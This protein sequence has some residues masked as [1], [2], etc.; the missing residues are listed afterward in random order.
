MQPQIGPLAGSKAL[1]QGYFRSGTDLLERLRGASDGFSDDDYASSKDDR[2]SVDGYC[3]NYGSGAISLSSKNRPVWLFPRL[4]LS[5]MH[6]VT[7]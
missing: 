5:F 7:P 4:R 6:L 3:V 1:S 2:K